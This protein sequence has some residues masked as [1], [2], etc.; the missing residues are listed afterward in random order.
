VASVVGQLVAEGVVTDTELPGG[1]SMEHCGRDRAG[2]AEPGECGLGSVRGHQGV[3]D[4]NELGVDFAGSGIGQQNGEPFP[5]EAAGAAGVA[6][7]LVFAAAF[8]A[9]EDRADTDATSAHGVTI[10]VK[11]GQRAYHAAAGTLLGVVVPAA[12]TRQ[13]KS[14]VGQ[15]RV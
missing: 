4:G 15:D 1:E 9:G 3:V 8:G 10:G 5:Q 14:P 7:G 2:L 13:A 11:V 6:V 12:S